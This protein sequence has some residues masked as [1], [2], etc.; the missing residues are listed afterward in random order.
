MPSDSTPAARSG[1]LSPRDMTTDLPAQYD[2]LRQELERLMAEPEKDFAAID[3]LVDR[4]ERVQLA[5]KEQ[6]G[7]KGNNPFE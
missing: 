2:R 3:E 5:I 4:L 7:V 1:Y 6:Q